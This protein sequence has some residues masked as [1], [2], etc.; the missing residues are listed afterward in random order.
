MALGPA[1]HPVQ[2]VPGALCLGEKQPECET[3]HSPPSCARVKN[4]YN[5][6]SNPSYAFM[7]CTGFTLPFIIQHLD[8]FHIGKILNNSEKLDTQFMS[9]E[10]SAILQIYIKDTIR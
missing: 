8:S 2:Q 9:R 7:A 5:Y 6:T 10:E 4:E 3:N 1:Q